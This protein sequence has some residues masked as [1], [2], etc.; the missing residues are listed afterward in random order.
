MKKQT[1]FANQDERAK[2]LRRLGWNDHFERPATNE[3]LDL[4]RVARVLSAQRDRFLVT[5]GRAEWLCSPSGKMRH[6]RQWDYPV[7]GDWVLVDESVVQHVLPRKNTLCRGEAGSRGKQDG[8]APREQP[9]AANL[10]TVF[11]V[12]GLDRDYNPRR[13]ERYLALVCNCGMTPVIVLTKTDLHDWPDAVRAETE[14]LAPGVPV[15]LTSTLDGSGAGELH[16]YLEPGKTAAMIG[17]S[18]AGKSSLA[19][20][21]LGEAVQTTAAVSR[22]VGKGRH[23]TTSREL[24]ALPGGGLLMDNPGIREIAFASDGAGLDAAFSDIRELAESCRFADCSHRHEPGCAVLHA[25]DAGGLSQARL[26]NYR[27]MQREMDYAQASSEKSADRVE[28]ERWKDV[29]KAIKRMNKR[30]RR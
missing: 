25:V 14:G 28:K 20:M 17:S 11:I 1:L 30:P 12:C 4:N 2:S 21:L 26:D 27:K 7:T 22:S 24:I 23:T 19:N 6:R 13:L 8:A 18:G 9:I 5:D 15:V 16:G 10:D 29:A 3:D